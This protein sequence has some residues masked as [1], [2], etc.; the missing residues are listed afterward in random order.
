VTLDNDFPT[1]D[2]TGTDYAVD[3]GNLQILQATRGYDDV[4]GVGTP[5]ARYVQ[6]W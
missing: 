2:G 6:R 5:T 3:F 1:Q 4:T